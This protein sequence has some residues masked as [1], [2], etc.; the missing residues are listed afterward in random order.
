MSSQC[1]HTF[2][3]KN[4]LP[5]WIRPMRADDTDNLIDIFEHLSP[6]SRYLRF[7]EPLISPDPELVRREAS[8]MATTPPHRGRG[9]LAFADLPDQPCAPI[10]GARYVRLSEGATTAEVALSV[11]DDLQN[12]GIGKELLRLLLEEAQ[13]DGIETLIAIVQAN[14]RAV[15]NLLAESPFPVERS[16]RRGETYVKVRLTPT[17]PTTGR[18]EA[19]AEIEKRSDEASPD[20]PPER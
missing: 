16:T 8:R 11:R 1:P 2:Q 4:G 17:A 6:E 3:A 9:W 7:H 19:V 13:A 12:Q 20:S 5:V 18:R 14:N 15:M 10:G